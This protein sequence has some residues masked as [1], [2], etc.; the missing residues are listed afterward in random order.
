MNE[1]GNFRVG[2]DAMARGIYVPLY[3]HA[4]CW[5]TS[6][7]ELDR[8]SVTPPPSPHITPPHPAKH[9]STNC[10]RLQSPR[11]RSSHVHKCVRAKQAC[12]G[13][14]ARTKVHKP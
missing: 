13:F 14:V 7:I 9:A 10:A 2:V 8:N 11:Q 6:C 5:L 12:I 1:A 3:Q 4:K